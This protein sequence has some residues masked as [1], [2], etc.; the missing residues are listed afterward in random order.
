MVDGIVSAYVSRSWNLA[1][2]CGIGIKHRTQDHRHAF[3]M[4]S[5]TQIWRVGALTSNVSL[6]V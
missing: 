3:H 2:T 4:E 6:R 1:H 5:S